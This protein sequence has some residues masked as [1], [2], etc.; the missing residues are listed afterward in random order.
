MVSEILSI[1]SL[2]AKMEVFSKAD[3]ISKLFNADNASMGLEGQQ[4]MKKI[5]SIKIP[6]ER[7]RNGKQHTTNTVIPS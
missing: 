6:S 7:D 2:Q 1:E 5:T 4:F 3:V